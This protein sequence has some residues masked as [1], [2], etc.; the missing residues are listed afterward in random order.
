[1][2]TDPIERLLQQGLD[3]YGRNEVDRAVRC[4]LEVLTLDPAHPTAR[5]YLESAGVDSPPGT[6]LAREA[7]IIDFRAF[8]AQTTLDGSSQP[9]QETER[10]FFFKEQLSQLLRARRYQEAL[11]LLCQVQAQNP[12]NLEVLRSIRLLRERLRQMP[13]RPRSEQRVKSSRHP[14]TLSETGLAAAQPAQA[15]DGF[16]ALFQRATEAYM[17]RDFEEAYRLFTECY[18]RRPDDRRVS[19]NLSALK[20]RLGHA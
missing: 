10:H 4:W 20:R 5:D 3:H 8:R 17:L 9:V 19:H 1:M 13:E 7:E 2:A 12:D 16:R 14:A 6:P 18:K 15:D 11:D